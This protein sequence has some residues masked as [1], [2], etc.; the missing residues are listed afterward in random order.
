MV[1]ASALHARGGDSVERRGLR[2]PGGGHGFRVLRGV[3]G[4]A[5]PL[6]SFD[7]VE[8]A[9]V[10]V[11]VAVD[12]LHAELEPSALPLDVAAV[13]PPA[14]IQRGALAAGAAVAPLGIRRFLRVRVAAA[15]RLLAVAAA[16]GRRAGAAAGLCVRGF[17]VAAGFGRGGAARD[18]RARA[19]RRVQARANPR[20]VHNL[21][22]PI[23]RPVVL[24][25]ARLRE[26]APSLH[27]LLEC[28]RPRGRLRA[29]GG[30]RGRRRGRHR[31]LRHPNGPN[32]QFPRGKRPFRHLG[33]AEN[34]AGATRSRARAADQTRGFVS[35]SLAFSRPCA[36]SSR[37][38]G[39]SER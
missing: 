36:F 21:P 12:L 10:A 13:L 14:L 38:V 15:A 26:G 31:G 22:A 35:R 34:L 19:R 27:A 25:A 39:H 5:L 28:R 2:L 18:G 3:V 23:L 17:T 30:L 9:L 8:H 33:G 32:R 4:A 29:L 7:A 6:G 11:D 37:A 1:L 20:A 16:R 24:P